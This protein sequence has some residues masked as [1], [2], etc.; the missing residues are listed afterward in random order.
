MMA[1]EEKAMMIKIIHFND[2]Y[3]VE[4]GE[5][6]PVGGAA[7]FKTKIEQLRDELHSKFGGSKEPLVLFSGDALGPSKSKNNYMYS[8]L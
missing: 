4:P 8:K 7:R 5:R 1:D 6:E 2:V 3:N